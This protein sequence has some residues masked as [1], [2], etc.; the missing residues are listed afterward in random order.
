MFW[1]GTQGND[2]MTIDYKRQTDL[3]AGVNVPNLNKG[4]RVLDAWTPNNTSSTIPALT[5]MDTN[6]ETRVS[7][8]YVENGSFLK[9][10]T[11]Q[12]GYNLPTDLV[13]KLYM[14]RVRLYLSAQNLLTIKGG[15]YSGVDP[16]VPTFGYPIPLN[17]T[18]GLNVSF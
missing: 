18:F 4:I 11:I 16:E 10:R 17:V 9:L 7:S 3:W 15:S 6:N 1:Q 12:F 5:T 8:Y 2:V 13:K 14:Q